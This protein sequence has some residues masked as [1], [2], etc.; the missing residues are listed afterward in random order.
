MLKPHV[1]SG[2]SPT[3]KHEAQSLATYVWAIIL[4]MSLSIHILSKDGQGSQIQV[5]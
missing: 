2:V 4:I 1:L 3:L 5:K